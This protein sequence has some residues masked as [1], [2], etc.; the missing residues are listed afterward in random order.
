M[1]SGIAIDNLNPAYVES[2]PAL[3]GSRQPLDCGAVDAAPASTHRL[4]F[5]LFILVNAVLFVRPAEI[6]PGWENLPIY[7]ILILGC[8]LAS[9]PVV[10][11]KLAWSSLRENPITVCVLGLLVAVFVSNA[12]HGDLWSARMGAMEFSK[13]V[14]YYLLLVGLI[15]SPARLRTFLLVIAG[16]I[17]CTA[18]LSLLNHH[19]TIDLPSLSELREGYGEDSVT[20]ET[21]YI[22]RLRAMGIFNDPNDFALILNTAIFI[23]LHWV[24]MQ[25]R[26][27][28]K[29]A[30]ALPIALL[31]YALTLTQSR[32]GFLSLLAGLV[33]LL[34]LHIRWKR[35]IF[36]CALLLPAMLLAFGGRLTNIDVENSNDTAQGRVLLWRDSLELFHHVPLFGIGQGNL[37]DEIGHVAHN[38]YVHGY[39]E[40]GFFGGTFFVG[41]FYLAA[42]AIG[43]LRP[44]ALPWLPDDLRSLRLCLLPVLASYMMGL[45]SLSRTYGNA[46]YMIFGLLAAFMTLVAAAGIQTPTLNPRL[47]RRVVV[48]SVGCVL[49]FEVFVRVFAH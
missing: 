39:A 37:A 45:H 22:Y 19:G 7:E 32:G 28:L 38:S 30:W 49:Y 9:L 6:V 24:L 31:V 5:A 29:L 12:A 41:A 11:P 4:G 13:V 16:F 17:F 14:I 10:L 25:K 34:F 43:K 8:L 20:G 40:M 35:A 23:A 2:F 15:D 44:V 18:I 26:W 48:A 46:T 47:A 3:R 36:V 21:H 1:H 42:T 27:L 33:V